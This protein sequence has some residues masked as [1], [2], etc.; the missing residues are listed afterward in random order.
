MAILACVF[1]LFVIGSVYCF[2]G[3]YLSFIKNILN[4]HISNNSKDKQL[5][6]LKQ[7]NSQ[8]EDLKNDL[9]SRRN[10]WL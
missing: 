8:L 2:F 1:M 5:E 3:E 6:M 7:I 10:I 9:D 4:K